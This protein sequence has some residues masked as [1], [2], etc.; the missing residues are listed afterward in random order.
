MFGKRTLLVVEA[1]EAKR[2]VLTLNLNMVLHSFQ[3]QVG[4]FH[5]PQADKISLDHRKL[6]SDPFHSL[7]AAFRRRMTV[8]NYWLAGSTANN[9]SYW[10]GHV[11]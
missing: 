1:L 3:R 9:G 6:Q 8:I 2:V 7:T 4:L 10:A 11:D 5:W